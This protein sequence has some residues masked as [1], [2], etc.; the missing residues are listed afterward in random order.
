MLGAAVL[1]SLLVACSSAPPPCEPGQGSFGRCTE[2]AG[3]RPQCTEMVLGY[4]QDVPYNTVMFPNIVGH[5]TRLETEI[6]AEYLLLSV[7]HG[8]LNGECS[9]DL[10]LLGCSILAP[11]C[12]DSTLLKPCR[13]SCEI[14]R[15]SCAHAFEAIQMAWPYFLDCDRFFVGDEEGCYDP[16]SALRA[17]QDVTFSSLSDGGH[18]TILQFT[19]HSNAQMFNILKKTAAKCPHIAQTYSIGRSVEG[20]DLLVIEFSDNPGQHELL[21]PE[22][23]LIGNMHGN[24]VLGRQLLIYLAQYLCSEY[25][26][27]NER[28]QTLINNTRIHL[29]PSMNP[30][31]YELAASEVADSQDPENTNQEGHIYNGW[32]SG[33]ANAQNIDLNRNFPD[34]TSIYYNRRRFRHFRSDHIPIPDSY[35]VNKVAPETYAV[36]KWIRTIPFVISASLHGGELVISYPFDFSRHPEEEKMF[37]PTPDEQIFKQLART[38]ADAHTTMSNND[39]D[40]CGATFASKGGIINGALWYSFA[41]GMSD[42]NYL[43]SNC[44]ELTVELGCDKFPGEEELYPEW[45]RNKEALLSFMES[46]HR[47]IKGVV[48]DRNGNGIKGAIISVKGIRH[49]ITTAEDGD[50]WRLLNP[51]IHIVSATA[52]GYSKV[53]K[54]IRLPRNMQKVGQV[55]FVLEKVPLEPDLDYFNIPELDNYERFDP[56]NQFE[57]Y[58]QRELGENGEERTDKPWWW[59]YFSQLGISSPTWLL[60]NY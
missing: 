17:R 29:L 22:I 25:V 31:G 35:W 6:S 40:R 49:D 28:I 18:A 51:G 12:Q 54:R 46:V 33:R 24:E 26:L 52:K 21:E 43:H 55:D 38:Y 53:M 4:C 45:R 11:R 37:S 8:L 23:K 41:G 32:T 50:Y 14:V 39:T 48:K 27:G 16:L 36:M 58:S 9:P 3:E 60:R 57:Q 2:T 47:G 20:K 5:Q 13:S 19:Y 59:T 34:L 10:R 15:K 7:L 42:F 30:D 1:L 44:L 56:Y